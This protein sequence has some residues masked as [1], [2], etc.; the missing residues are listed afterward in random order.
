MNHQPFENWLLSEET[1]PVENAHLL[2]EHLET[3]TH[4]QELQDAWMSIATL[5][6]AVPDMEPVPGFVDRWQIRLETDRQVDLLGRHRWQSVIMLI[7]IGNVITGLVFLLSTQFLTTFETP[8]Q[9]VLSWVYR[10]AAMLTF[11]NGLQ[12]LFST[13]FR[14]FTN[15][16]P[17]GFWAILG[18]GL[19]GSGAIWV[20]TMKS[21]SVLP[22]R[23]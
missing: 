2:G 18:A 7:L 3:C 5:F 8:T 4:C 11:V 15:I 14:T 23:T 6:T 19:V 1:L 12:N 21:L 10:L 13:L 22:R 9:L 17:A 20:I 16:V